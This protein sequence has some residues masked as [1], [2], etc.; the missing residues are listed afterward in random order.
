MPYNY[1]DRDLMIDP[2]YH[3]MYAKFEGRQFLTD[4]MASRKAMRRKLGPSD[5]TVSGD[6]SI[7]GFDVCAPETKTEDILERL[8]KVAQSD[9]A[10]SSQEVLAWID[11]FA[12]KFEASKRL[13]RS[14][15]PGFLPLDRA[16]VRRKAYAELAFL[17][18]SVIGQA[19][20]L[21][22]LNALLKL[23]DL[24]LSGPELDQE[25][26]AL[27]G[28][29]IDRELECVCVLATSLHVMPVES[30]AC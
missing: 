23:N 16:P 22:L 10:A 2:P 1:T 9:S 25:T 26:A 12:R 18:A 24:V 11:L 6:I 28:Y 21:R 29:A 20:N 7:P 13:R 17:I 27:L 19:K 14:Y 5:M 4:Y 8:V 30:D 3:Y 15:G